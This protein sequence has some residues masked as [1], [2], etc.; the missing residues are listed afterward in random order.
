MR[1]NGKLILAFLLV[2]LGPLAATSVLSYHNAEKALTKEVLNH[3]ETVSATQQSRIEGILDQ[4]LERLV[5]VSSRT[6][7]RLSLASFIKEPKGEYQDMMNQILLDA[8]SSIRD[9]K[10]ISVLTMDGKIVASTDPAKIGTKAA[11]EEFFVRGQVENCVDIFFLDENRNL[12]LY[13]SG[14]LYLEGKLLGVVVIE[15]NVENILS[16]VRDYSG[17]GETGETLLAKR[18]ENGDALFLTPLRFDRDAALRRTVLKDDLS[19]AVTQALLKN[20]GI[21]TEAVDYREEQVLA[22]AKYVEKTGWGVV[23]KIDR[24]E[25]FA[26]IDRLRN[27]LLGIGFLTVFAVTLLA[28]ISAESISRPIQKLARGAEIIGKG[29]FGHKI[30]VRSKDEIGELAASFNKMATDLLAQHQALRRSIDE[31]AAV[32]EIDRNIVARP[33]LSSLLRFIVD[34]ARELTGADAAFYSFVEGRVIRHHTFLGIRTKAFKSIKLRKGSGLGWYVVEK[35]EPVAVED[36]F[37]DE[38]LKDAPYEA[39]KKE[40]LVSLLAVPVLS[41]R[42]KPMGVLY[43]A[44]RRKTRFTEEQVRTLVTLA[45]QSSVAVEHARLYEETKKAYEELKTLEELKSN[46]IANVSHELRTPITIAKSAVQLAKVEENVEMRKKLLQMVAEA[47]S[48][49][50][51]IV[52]N[53]IEAA[54]S[55]RTL[56]LE[57]VDMVEVVVQICSEFKSMALEGNITMSTNV[58]DGLPRVKADC[59]QLEHVLRNLISNALK[60]NKKGGEILIE[61]RRRGSTVEVSVTDTGIG[62]PKEA[63]EKI[64]QRFY[65]VDSSLTRH[66]GGTGMGLSIA[67]EIVEA[68]GGK[69]AVESE[70]GKGSRFYFTLP[71]AIERA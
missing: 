21:F 51:F 52:G 24:A 45:A 17:L 47:L 70:L 13:L 4:N 43:V 49:Q 32:N 33:D 3:L 41:A 40:G 31:L 1:I 55:K 9:F 29:D 25:A 8:R 53:L 58:E 59:K 28:F 60:F 36:F 57:E 23:V 71:I 27:V 30:H 69:I 65:Q 42:A 39:V 44:N 11:G 67:K 37:A 34:K 10:D 54:R 68:H 66:Y 19:E 48:R 62:I 38:R 35:K 22:A 46:I 64:F 2:S 18:D 61:A 12:R 15:A 56:K 63:Q 20:V 16:L 5:L 7:L 14:P 6:Q 26:P 50:N